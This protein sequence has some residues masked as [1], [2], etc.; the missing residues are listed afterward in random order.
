MGI[1]ARLFG[2]DHDQL[3][4]VFQ[5]CRSGE[6]IEVGRATEC[7]ASF[8]LAVP[9]HLAWEEECLFPLVESPSG[10]IDAG[11]THVM[12][13]EHSQMRSPLDRIHER[14]AVGRVDTDQLDGRLLNLL[15]SHN[16]KAEDLL[17]PWVNRMV[18]DQDAQA[19]VRRPQD[20]PTEHEEACRDRRTAHHGDL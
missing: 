13:V 12:R 5:E 19:L 6:S 14:L 10:Q 7:V 11:P 8:R 9:R 3:D 17:S 18:S 4:T 2:R 20:P 1:V 15:T 16:R